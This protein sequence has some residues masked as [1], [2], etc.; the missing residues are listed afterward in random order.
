MEQGKPVAWSYGVTTVPARVKSHLPRTLA[1]LARGGFD[2]PRLFVD[3]ASLGLSLA[4]QEIFNLDVSPRYPH[5]GLAANW[6][7]SMVELYLHS[8]VADYYA[9]FQDDLVTVKNLRS[10]L[11]QRPYPE[12][13]Y[14]NL[15]RFMDNEGPTKSRPIGWVEGAEMA[16]GKGTSYHGKMQQ[17]GRGALA[18]VFSREALVTLFLQPHFVNR[19]QDLKRGRIKI[20]GGIVESMNQAGW[21]EYVHNPSLVSH[22]GSASTKGHHWHKN[23]K[24]FP[25]ENF[26]ALSLL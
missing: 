19:P 1:S 4:L 2:R 9:L 25:G 22:T 16:T 6:S 26:N 8:P 17:V 21:R 20:D 5:I 11:E 7:L 14:L 18:L 15:F 24:T 23:A 12:N 3:G 10:Y 13:G